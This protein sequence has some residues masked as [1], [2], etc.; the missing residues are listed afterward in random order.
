MNENDLWQKGRRSDQLGSTLGCDL[1]LLCQGKETQPR[2]QNFRLDSQ[3]TMHVV[4]A[5]YKFSNAMCNEYIT[6]DGR[7][8]TIS[9]E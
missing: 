9:S 1:P 8:A 2:K 7:K 5:S 6:S 4:V 3:P